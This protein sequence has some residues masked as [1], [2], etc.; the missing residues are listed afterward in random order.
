[1]TR[2]WETAVRQG[3]LATLTRLIEAGA[4]V[5]AKDQ[6]GQTGLM[7][8]AHKGHAD[9]VRLLLNHGA[10]LDHTAKF[11]LSA[12]ML[13]VLNGRTEIVRAL[14]DSGADRSIRGSG[15]PGFYEKTAL[16]LAIDQQ[17]PDLIAALQP[18]NC[19]ISRPRF[20]APACSSTRLRMLA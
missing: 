5:N 10:D 7:V 18:T 11:H 9:L 19:R 2:E 3:D 17:R 15:A 13:A 16:E 6:H 4:D 1:M 20:S 14:V 8:A 12:L